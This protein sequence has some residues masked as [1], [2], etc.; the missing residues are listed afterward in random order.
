MI[1]AV[2]YTFIQPLN[3][4]NKTLTGSVLLLFITFL[5]GNS[6]L[7]VISTNILPS[8]TICLAARRLAHVVLLHVGIF[9]TLKCALP[10]RCKHSARSPFPFAHV[11]RLGSCHF[12]SRFWATQGLPI[13]ASGLHSAAVQG[14]RLSLPAHPS[15]LPCAVSS[16]ALSDFISSHSLLI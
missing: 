6:L 12:H 13:P 1:E 4:S 3:E 9:Q 8:E 2:A 14:G 16:S 10:V 7:R 15:C 11:Q 5:R